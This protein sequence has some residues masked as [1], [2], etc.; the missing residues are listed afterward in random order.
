[1]D[2]LNSFINK[3][4][5]FLEKV[6][7]E[8]DKVDSEVDDFNR[9]IENLSIGVIRESNKLACELN[10]PLTLLQYENEPLP[11]TI[12][13]LNDFI[14][15]TPSQ[16][17]NFLAYYQLEISNNNLDNHTNLALYLGIDAFV[18]QYQ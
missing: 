8:L 15:L 16:V 9:R 12:E 14:H 3:Q 11:H 13:T 6:A 10:S 7:N 18:N 17:N 1:M 5:Q 4:R 2:D